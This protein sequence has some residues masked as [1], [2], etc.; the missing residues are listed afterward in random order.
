MPTLYSLTCDHCQKIFTRRLGLAL[1]YATTFC[2]LN[3]RDLEHIRTGNIC[4][5]CGQCGRPVT[6]VRSAYKSSKSGK[7]FCD[8]HCAATYANT[9]KTTGCR[10][11][12]LEAWLEDNL[13]EAYPDLDLYCNKKDAIN[14]E[15]DFYFPGLRLAFELNGIFHYKP[16]HGSS[17]LLQTQTN[18]LRKFQACSAA[19]ISLCVVDTSELIHFG[20][21]RAQKFLE[22]IRRIVGTKAKE[23]ANRGIQFSS[24]DPTRGRTADRQEPAERPRNLGVFRCLERAMVW[25]EEITGGLRRVDLARREHISPAY[26]TYIMRM[27]GLPE[28]LKFRILARDPTLEP[29]TI[30]QALQIAASPTALMHAPVTR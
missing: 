17:Q 6:R 10:R 3:C 11:S 1:R 29:I 20:E 16:I 14:F 24:T 9:H 27:L 28:D 26:V 2:S 19:E 30:K 22:T 8:H 15:L 21:K 4:L 7:V 12:R 25:S 23:L 13:R 5:P 18:D